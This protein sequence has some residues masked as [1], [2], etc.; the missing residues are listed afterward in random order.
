M[1]GWKPQL[2]VDL[3]FG[4]EKAD[5]Y[6]TTST[7]FV[8]QLHERL[9]WAYKTAQ[10]IIEKENH[11]HKQNFDNEIRWTQLGVGDMGFIRRTAFK[12]KHKIQE[13]KPYIMLRD[14]H[15]QGCQFS[16]LPQLQGKVR[17]KLETETCYSHFEATLRGVLR[18]REV[19]K[20]PTEL[21]IA[22]WQSLMIVCQGL[23]LCQQILTLWV[24]VMQSMYSV[25]E[26]GK[27]Q[28]IWL[29]PHG[30]G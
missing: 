25:Y 10:N 6:A 19:N 12:G 11:R 22:S 17:W 7:K 4:N 13:K 9:K 30:D 29:K 2:P 27:S 21:R 26:L 1:C 24:M 28:I 23:R 16:R 14:S 20:M 3:Y 15:M 5:M 18:M 8:Q